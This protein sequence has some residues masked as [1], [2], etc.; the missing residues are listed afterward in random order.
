MA[1][2]K[3][4]LDVQQETLQNILTEEE[5][6]KLTGLRKSQLANCRAKKRLPFLKVSQRCRLYLESDLVAWLKRFRIA[7]NAD[8]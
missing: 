6:L 2:N 7:V 1:E 8:E 5:V 3:S 4:I